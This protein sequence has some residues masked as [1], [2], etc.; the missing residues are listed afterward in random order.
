MAATTLGCAPDHG[1]RSE[2]AIAVVNGVEIASVD[3]DCLERLSR[4]PS[5]LDPADPATAPNRAEILVE[6]IA[7]HLLG[8]EA[9]RRR[10]EINA[11]T[12]AADALAADIAAGFDPTE[13]ELRLFYD[14]HPQLYLR[15]AQMRTLHCRGSQTDVEFPID[16]GSPQLL[17]LCDEESAND[18]EGR[19]WGD[20]GW[21]EAGY[22]SWMRYGRWTEEGVGSTA[23]RHDDR[24]RPHV[25]RSM[26]FRPA[27]RFSFDQVRDDCRLRL[28]QE[29]T[30]TELRGL[31]FDLATSAEINVLDEA[32]RSAV[33]PAA[34]ARCL[35]GPPLEMLVGDPEARFLSEMVRVS[36]AAFTTGSTDEEID[37]RLEICRQWV[38][39]A[40]GE[41]TCRRSNYEDEVRRE[42]T[43]GSF[44]I[45]RVEVSWDDYHAF[46]DATRHRPLPVHGSGGPDLPV[47]NVSQSDAAA[48]CRWTGKRLPT[49]DEWELAARGAE[50]RRHPWGNEAADGSR[51]N[52]CDAQCDRPWRNT[53]HDDGYPQVAPPGSYPAGATSDGVFDL[54]GNL[55][56]WTATI[57]GDR[58][59][60]K[61]GG[62]ENAIDDL[63]A[64]DVR[65]NFLDTRDPTMGFRCAADVPGPGD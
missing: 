8:R 14:Q 37:V 47:S 1:R 57:E 25:F 12:L 45:D 32:L 20:L 21:V 49:A 5:G 9:H 55:R 40:L 2:D 38:D 44:F 59:H 4:R 26:H 18:A 10:I 65:L 48:Y 13:E 52:F 31:L 36:G 24:G 16:I 51:A 39:P 56:E 29:W 22:A 19:I 35:P 58:A 60:V 17:S 53:D 54:G 30:R 27:A 41:G 11:G 62:Y 6:V 43:L 3:V 28:V 23:V 15:P 7:H 50:S 64:A 33:S 63:I 34:V 46:L 61:G 42:V